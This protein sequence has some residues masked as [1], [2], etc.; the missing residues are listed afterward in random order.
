MIH[1][2]LTVRTRPVALKENTVI[3]GAV[4]VT[5]LTPCLFR[6]ERSESGQFCDSATQ[7]VWYRD[8]APVPFCVKEEDLLTAWVH[9]LPQPQRDE[10]TALYAEMNA[11]ETLEAKI[12][13]A[14][15]KLEAVIQHNESDIATWLP[16]E[17]DLQL[18]YGA[19]NVT[20]SAYMQGLKDHID[21]WTREKIRRASPAE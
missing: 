13:K 3:K 15:D 8:M 1:K 20:F 16:L 4:R 17:Y 14:I 2:H 18:R 11:R 19:E 21:R 6:V 12:Y 5:V 7:R 10:M 9:T